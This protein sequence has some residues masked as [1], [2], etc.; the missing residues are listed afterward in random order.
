MLYKVSKNIEAGVFAGI[1][2]NL[3]TEKEVDSEH[4]YARGKDISQLLR[5]A[6]RISY[7]VDKF[8]FGVEYSYNVASYGV[9][10]PDAHNVYDKTEDAANSRILL[11]AVYKF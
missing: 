9:G 8:K 10:M 4:I 3:G 2:Q 5:I 7:S 11:T 6:P 1:T